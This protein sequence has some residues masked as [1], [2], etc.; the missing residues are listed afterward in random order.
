MVID[1]SLPDHPRL[2]RAWQVGLNHFLFSCFAPE[3][4]W[5]TCFV[6]A[7][8]LQHQNL[9]HIPGLVLGPRS[10]PQNRSRPGRPFRDYLA[11]R[12]LLLVAFVTTPEITVVQNR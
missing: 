3:L 1:H 5:G 2:D 4:A 7:S 6:G 10:G 9:A 8:H 11:D 12:G